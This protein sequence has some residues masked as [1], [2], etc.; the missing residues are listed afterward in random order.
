MAALLRGACAASCVRGWAAARRSLS[1]GQ[2][3]AALRVLG[4][5]QGA[6]A[7]QVKAA[8]I[9]LAKE[10]HPDRH[11]GAGKARA[12]ERFK[13]V[14]RAAQELLEAGPSRAGAA[15]AGGSHGGAARESR[16]G[17]AGGAS[18]ASSSQWG[19]YSQYGSASRAGYDPFGS[20]YF[21]ADS[22]TEAARARTESRN[23]NRRM[24]SF[25]VYFV[26]LSAVILSA[27]SN[28]RAREAGDKVDAYYNQSTRR[29]EPAL[30]QMLRDPLLSQMVHLKPAA[31][32]H[33]P[34]HPGSKR[35]SG[36][37]RTLDGLT[38]TQ[39]YTARMAGTRSGA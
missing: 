16:W 26:G 35:P 31:D 30:P 7:T 13:L 8:Y 23:Q 28:D 18:T 1:S 17:A 33:R 22:E 9:Q 29:W 27:R 10:W 12:E 37:Q 20:S 34:S 39:A 3:S 21:R 11:P 2:A 36:A 15:H 4:L 14:Q 38:P 24:I 32:V 25:S 19:T 5:D 6:S